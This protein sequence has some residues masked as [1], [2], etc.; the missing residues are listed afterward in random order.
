MWPFATAGASL[1]LGWFQRYMLDYTRV[2]AKLDL[3]IPGSAQQAGAA[4]GASG[5]LCSNWEL[6]AH[7]SCKECASG[8][9]V[10]SG[11]GAAGCKVLT[12]IQVGEECASGRWVRFGVVGCL[13]WRVRGLAQ[14]DS[15]A[16][17]ARLWGAA[18]AQGG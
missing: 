16:S 14:Q 3:G 5:M 2:L 6:L 17:A 8:G 18:W 7:Q 10:G 13:G 1:Q 11:R 9:Q 4:G 12:H 15:G